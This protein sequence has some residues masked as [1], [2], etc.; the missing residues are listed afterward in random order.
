MLTHTHTHTHTFFYSPL[1]NKLRASLGYMKPHLNP[2]IPLK[3]VIFTTAHERQ[4]VT[5]TYR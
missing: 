4:A 5:T 2:L 1:Y 3:T